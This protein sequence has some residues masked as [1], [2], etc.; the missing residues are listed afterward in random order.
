M[1]FELL[2]REIIR[3]RKCDNNLKLFSEKNIL[4]FFSSLKFCKNLIKIDFSRRF[5]L[6]VFFQRNNFI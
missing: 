3:E 6:R 4:T 1:L 5:N 2:N